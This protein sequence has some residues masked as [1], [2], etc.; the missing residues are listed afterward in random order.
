MNTIK[1]ANIEILQQLKF[2]LAQ[3]EAVDYKKPLKVLNNS[4][5]GQHN[6]HIVEFYQCLFLGID[7]K[8]VDYDA[9]KRDLQLETD[10]NYSIA[11]MDEII[12]KFHCNFEDTNLKLLVNLGSESAT[13]VSTT[14]QRELTYLIE[15]SIHHLAIINIALR[16][17]YAQIEIPR[18]FGVAFSTIIHQ[19]KSQ[20]FA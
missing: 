14:F 2:V 20:L 16:D 10:L 12:E 3:I 18:N 1:K 7:S 9:R 15:H 13:N 5:I 6:R 11:V 8:I 17:S 19:E 4:T